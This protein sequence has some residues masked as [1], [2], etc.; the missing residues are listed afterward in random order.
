MSFTASS[1]GGQYTN[2]LEEGNLSGN[3]TVSRQT[4]SYGSHAKWENYIP[5]GWAIDALRDT[6]IQTNQPISNLQPYTSCHVWR[7]IS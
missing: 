2:I 1:E 6:G 5:E 4:T 3:I 7:R